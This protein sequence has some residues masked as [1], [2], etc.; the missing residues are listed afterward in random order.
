LEDF[1]PLDLPVFVFLTAG[2]ERGIEQSTAVVVVV[3]VVVVV[4]WADLKGRMH[5]LVELKK[6]PRKFQRTNGRKGEKKKIE[7]C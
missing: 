2:S 3:D 4:V 7:M 1:L 6:S 5:L